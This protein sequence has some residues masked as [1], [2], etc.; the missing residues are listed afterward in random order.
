MSR[1]C[2][3]CASPRRLVIDT[4]LQAGRTPNYIEHEMKRLEQPT[5][6]ET[7][8]RHI[9]TCLG[10]NLDNTDGVPLDGDA[11]T[12]RSVGGSQDFA[13]AVRSEAQRLLDMGKLKVT[14]THGLQAQGLIDRRAEEQADRDLMM[15][16]AGILSGNRLP[17]PAEVIDIEGEYTEITPIA[18]PE[19]TT[20]EV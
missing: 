4:L 8:R 18:P 11:L 2:G 9:A 13:A 16:L 10:G 17:I 14:A 19:L 20:A 1:Q 6:A 3:I 7:I 15:R 5:K 12:I